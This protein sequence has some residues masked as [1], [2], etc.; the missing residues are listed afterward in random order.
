MFCVCVYVCLCLCVCVDVWA[1]HYT[2]SSQRHFEKRTNKNK[3]K[4]NSSSY[5]TYHGSQ[6]VIQQTHSKETNTHERDKYTRK[7]KTHTYFVLA[8]RYELRLLIDICRVQPEPGEHLRWLLGRVE[9]RYV[10]PHYLMK[11]T[12][13]IFLMNLA[14][15][16]V[17]KIKDK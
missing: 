10:P 2:F 8:Q 12:R 11:K 9:A 1:E 16:I 7:K 3:S 4:Q 15:Y 17:K 5:S 14:Q 6:Y 13:S